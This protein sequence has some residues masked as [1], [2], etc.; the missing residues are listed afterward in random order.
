MKRPTTFFACF[1]S[2]IILATL[3]S[4]DTVLQYPD[5]EGIDP[6]H[7]EGKTMLH[8]TAD[9][10]FALLGEFE[11]DFE[12]TYNTAANIARANIDS[13]T[14][15]YTICAYDIN[16]K[17]VSPIPKAK[18]TFTEPIS[19]D[20][21][22][23]KELEILPGDYRLV[24]WADYVDAN[25]TSDKYYDTTDFAEIILKG[26]DGHPGSN[27]FRDAFY[28]E[29]IVHVNLPNE[30]STNAEVLLNRPA[31]KY[32]FVSNDLRE[33]L[34]KEEARN[35][36]TS[37]DNAPQQAPPLSDYTV[38]IVYTRYMPCSFNVHT[39]KPIDSRTGVEYHSLISAMDG[40]N[41][42]LAFDYVFT[43]GTETSVAVA[44][45]VIHKDG[46]VVGRMPQFDVP[47]KRAH[48]TIITGKFLTTKSGGDIGINPEFDGSFNIMV[49]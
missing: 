48:H 12:N 10:K 8:I 18:F 27:P 30:P 40:D 44:M 24:V 20:I 32:T 9:T 7:P 21:D 45:E 42:Q 33:F 28:G 37:P 23:H 1:A 41:A 15:R 26:N 49:Q 35:K 29:T 25:S 22:T 2:I 6:N 11:Y 34:D 4:C 38:R 19:D 47:L 16:E 5:G 14:L 46:T 13:H 36:A 3:A 43:N 17:A 31:A 39:G